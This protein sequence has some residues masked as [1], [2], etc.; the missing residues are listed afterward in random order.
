VDG[1]FGTECHDDVR[2]QARAFAEAEIRPRIFDMNLVR[3]CL[4]HAH[5]RGS[6]KRAV[7]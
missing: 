4:F 7:A 6:V 5:D 3:P 2:E 1:Y